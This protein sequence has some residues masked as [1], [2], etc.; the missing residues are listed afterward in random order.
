MDSRSESS[1]VGGAQQRPPSPPDAQTRAAINTEIR[2]IARIAGLDQAWIDGQIDAAADAD[3]ARRAAFAALANRSAPTIR[4]EQV[5]IEMGDS[6]DDPT[7]RA[8]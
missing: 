4:T 8:R 7:Q 6:Q 3:S 5:R 2:S 1:I